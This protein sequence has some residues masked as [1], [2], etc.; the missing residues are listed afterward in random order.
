M[1]NVG[2]P[3]SKVLNT[4]ASN[5]NKAR[6]LSKQAQPGLEAGEPTQEDGQD[7]VSLPARSK[8]NN[9]NKTPEIQSK[10]KKN[11]NLGQQF[12]PGSSVTR[13]T[14]NNAGGLSA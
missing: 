7:H 8:S 4:S 2:P 6:S 12:H 14:T 9:L 3:P 10:F 5:I 1:I 11:E 13:Q